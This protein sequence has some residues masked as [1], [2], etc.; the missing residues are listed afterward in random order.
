MSQIKSDHVRFGV[1]KKHLDYIISYTILQTSLSK[2][3]K[4]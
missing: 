3:C 2:K 4:N 1:M